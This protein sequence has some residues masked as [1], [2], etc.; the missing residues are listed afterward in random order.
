MDL[1]TEREK[2]R[3]QLD[4]SIKELRNNGTIF[5]EAERNYKIAVNK[6]AL[7]LRDEGMPVTLIQTVIYG[8][9]EIATLRFKRD[10]A[11]V[12]YDANMEAIN[13]LKLQLRLL[14]NQIDKEW[15]NAKE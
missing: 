14:D 9:L 15:G 11:K 6:K 1:V 4:M 10:S 8:Y 2:K 3:S 12:I 5:A 13:S 7:Q